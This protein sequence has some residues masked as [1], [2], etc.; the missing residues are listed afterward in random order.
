[1]DFLRGITNLTSWLGNVIM[2]TLAALFFAIGILRYGKGYAHGYIPYAGFAC[3][4][5]SG[6]LRALETFSRQAA[7]NDA[8]LPWLMVR[9]LVDWTGNVFMPVYAVLQIVQ[10]ALAFGGVGH[11][12]YAGHAWMRHFAAAAMALMVS[13]LTRLAEFFVTSGTGGIS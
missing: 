8:D 4:M 6:L 12:I 7:W 13:A 1:M 11:R 3:L 5:V 2:P 9:G 10:G